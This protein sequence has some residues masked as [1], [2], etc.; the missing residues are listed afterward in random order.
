VR[1][2]YIG[3]ATS[4]RTKIRGSVYLIDQKCLVFFIKTASPP[5]NFFLILSGWQVLVFAGEIDRKEVSRENTQVGLAD[6][7]RNLYI[8]FFFARGK[9]KYP[10]PTHVYTTSVNPNPDPAYS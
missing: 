2:C 8:F 9:A 6:K 1:I 7:I 3:A 10:F 4:Y 5:Y